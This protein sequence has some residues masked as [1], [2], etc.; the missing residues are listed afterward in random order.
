MV[1]VIFARCKALA[2]NLGLIRINFHQTISLT[3]SFKCMLLVLGLVQLGIA[4]YYSALET[5]GSYS[6]LLAG[7][8]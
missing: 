5:F 8:S 3:I 7:Y 6:Q 4:V 1:D 2:V